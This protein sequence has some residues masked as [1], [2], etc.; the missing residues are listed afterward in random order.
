MLT[1]DRSHDPRT[2][3]TGCL[4]RLQRRLDLNLGALQ[5]QVTPKSVH[6]TRTATRRLRAILQAFK[7]H[8]SASQARGYRSA[9]KRVTRGL[10]QVRDADVANAYVANLV[11]VVH[12]RNRRKLDSLSAELHRRRLRLVLKLQARITEPSWAK[13]VSMLQ[14]AASANHLVLRKKEPIGTAVSALVTKRRRRLQA[15]LLELKQTPRALHRLRLRIKTLR[16]LCEEVG[17]FGAAGVSQEEVAAIVSLQECLGKLH[18][19]EAL[20]HEAPN[21][22]LPREL[23]SMVAARRKHLLRKYDKQRSRLLQLWDSALGNHRQKP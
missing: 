11:S 6:D 10:G 9:L 18:D 16:Y 13:R 15:R 23:R 4:A 5:R 7:P 17:D 2:S 3:V 1:P 14:S 19:L 12:H 8:L 21:N 20:R 22:R